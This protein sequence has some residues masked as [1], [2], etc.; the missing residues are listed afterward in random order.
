MPPSQSARQPVISRTASGRPSPSTSASIV[1]PRCRA[2]LGNV[3]CQLGDLPP[4]GGHVLWTVS[5]VL[6]AGAA[7]GLGDPTAL[8]TTGPLPAAQPPIPPIPTTSAVIEATNRNPRIRITVRPRP[9]RL[10]G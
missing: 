9:T 5:V 1:R 8:A 10:P 6:G 2:G 7:F 4:T 3:T